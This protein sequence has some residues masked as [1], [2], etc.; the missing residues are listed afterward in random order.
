MV[1]FL[2]ISMMDNEAS[3]RVPA[4]TAGVSIAVSDEFAQAAIPSKG[5]RKYRSSAAPI[6]I[7][8][9]CVIFGME[10]MPL[11][12][13]RTSSSLMDIPS[14]TAQAR[15]KPIM[16]HTIE[17]F[18]APSARF[19]SF[20]SKPMN[21]SRIQRSAMDGSS[22]FLR[23]VQIQSI[24]RELLAAITA[25]FVC[26]GVFTMP[27]IGIVFSAYVSAIARQ[28]TICSLI[29]SD[30]ATHA[31]LGDTGSGHVTPFKSHRLGP[32]GV[33]STVAACSY[34]IQKGVT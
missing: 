22:A 6:S 14:I 26:F 25:V 7:I 10:S 21:K 13:I 29:D 18:S 24:A 8:T 20:D 16:G 4:D 11:L 27:E 15:T 31:M 17:L 1:G 28:A 2:E 34:F 9:A 33:R 5:I 12:R 3:S 19:F 30:A 23:T 32:H